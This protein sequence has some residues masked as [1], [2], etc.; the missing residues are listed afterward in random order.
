L[1]PPPFAGQG[2]S[3]ALNHR[4]RRQR[5]RLATGSGSFLQEEAASKEPQAHHLLVGQLEGCRGEG[6]LT[7]RP[8]FFGKRPSVGLNESHARIASQRQQERAN[9]SSHAVLLPRAAAC[10]DD[11]AWASVRECHPT[12]NYTFDDDAESALRS[13]CLF[14]SRDD[15]QERDYPANLE[16][17]FGDRHTPQHDIELATE[18]NGVFHRL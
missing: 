1:R 13:E 7:E 16:D 11:P 5:N 4:N 15:V 8:Q 6:I 14:D 3:V 2:P 9:S 18:F 10:N 12:L 17:P